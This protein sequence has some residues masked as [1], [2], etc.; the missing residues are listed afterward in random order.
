MAPDVA[1]RTIRAFAEGI[2][3]RWRGPQHNRRRPRNPRRS[4]AHVA[5]VAARPGRPDGLPRS[6]ALPQPAPVTLSFLALGDSYTIGEGVAEG[7]R[8]PAQLARR[9]SEI[10]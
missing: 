8:W 9:L 2:R 3:A 4:S 6:A 7:D 1:L 5:R 10:R